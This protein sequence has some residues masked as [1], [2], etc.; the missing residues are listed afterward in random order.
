MEEGISLML[1][2]LQDPGNMGTII[3][4]ADWFGV[5]QLVCS[6]D[7]ADA[8]AP[9][10][11]Q[12]SMGSIVRV[13]LLYTPLAAFVQQHPGLKLYAATLGGEPLAKTGAI[14]EG[15]LV[16]GNEGR[17]VSPELLAAC[18]RQITI[19][20]LGHAESLNAAVATGILLSHLV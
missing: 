5:R 11:V 13:Q 15:M 8:F 3:R 9:K 12:G 4:T 6:P 18:Y 10:V 17:G 14:K 19:P 7:C 1:D 20:R 2:S 16:I